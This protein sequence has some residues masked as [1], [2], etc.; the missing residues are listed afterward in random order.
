MDAFQV[1]TA[2]LSRITEETLGKLN[3]AINPLNPDIDTRQQCTRQNKKDIRDRHQDQDSIT[4]RLDRLEKIADCAE[5]EFKRR[6]LKFLGIKATAK[7]YYTTGVDEIVDVLN[8]Y[9]TSHTWGRSDIDRAYRIG[10]R[11]H[12]ATSR[13]S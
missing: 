3:R 1:Q 10:E 8:E 5:M 11:R 2:N 12:A 13:E 6:N 4:Q 7:Q 9:C